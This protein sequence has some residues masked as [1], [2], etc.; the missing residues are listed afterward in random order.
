MITTMIG[1][2]TGEVILKDERGI[3]LETNG[4]GYRV[5]VL[6]DLLGNTKLGDKPSLWT[7]LA[8]KEDAM[9]LYGFTEK[10]ELDYFEL[11]IGISGI[12]PKTALGILSIAP[13]ETL[14]K[15]VSK[16]N[17]SYLT[18]VSGIG[19]KNAKKIV[20]ELKDKI[21]T[22]PDAE[23]SDLQEDEDTLLALR[24]L[25]Y[26]PKEAREALMHVPKEI[27]GTSQRIKEALKF[28]SK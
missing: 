24:S 11:L 3:I 9:D 2:L 25:G 16:E 6:G 28:L 13:P 18:K 5:S 17:I 7:Y 22:L 8:V 26:P 27:S 12:G 14:E 20:L 15:A 23:G 21:H 1:R 4:V 19:T 10:E